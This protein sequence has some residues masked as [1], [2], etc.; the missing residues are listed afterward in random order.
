VRAERC[1]H[2]TSLARENGALAARNTRWPGPG[3]RRL[4]SAAGRTHENIGFVE[5]EAGDSGWFGP[6]VLWGG[7]SS[8]EIWLLLSVCVLVN[9]SSL[10]GGK[11]KWCCHVLNNV[12]SIFIYL[13][14]VTQ[15]RFATEAL[16]RLYLIVEGAPRSALPSKSSSEFHLQYMKHH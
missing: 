16:V 11:D 6:E 10:H 15:N 12:R 13:L 9:G 7:R 1:C 4:V 2:G 14:T 5:R 8:C 3:R